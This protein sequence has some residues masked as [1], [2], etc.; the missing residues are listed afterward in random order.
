MVVLS[1]T[2]QSF[3]FEVQLSNA[4]ERVYFVVELSGASR[5]VDDHWC[6]YFV[7]ELNYAPKD[8]WLSLVTDIQYREAWVQSEDYV[9]TYAQY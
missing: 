9:Q 8:S 2:L 4:L 3:L 1:C 7:V 5:T 6:I